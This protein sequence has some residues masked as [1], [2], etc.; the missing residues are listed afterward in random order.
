LLGEILLL[1]LLAADVPLVFVAV[2][3]NVYAVPFVKPV[4]V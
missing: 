1:A 2:T 3:V 4:K